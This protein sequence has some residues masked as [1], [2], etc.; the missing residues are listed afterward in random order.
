M[1]VVVYQK[2]WKIPIVEV[3]SKTATSTGHLMLVK[4]NWNGFRSVKFLELLKGVKNL[5]RLCWIYS[6]LFG[7]N[8]EQLIAG[9]IMWC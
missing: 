9:F 1:T 4:F 7:Q 5:Y 3:T 8:M 6:F 2:I